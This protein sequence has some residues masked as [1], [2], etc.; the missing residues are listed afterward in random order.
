MSADLVLR[1]ALRAAVAALAEIP[2]P[3]MIIG[4]I[5]VIAAGVPRETV[6]VDATILGKAIDAVSVLDVFARHGIVPRIPNAL[7]FAR[8]RQV[9]LL[10]H[11]RSTVTMEVSFAWLPFEEEALARAVEVDFEGLKLRVAIPEDLIVYKAAAWRDRDVSD[12]E[13]LL[14]LHVKEVDL[15]RVRGLITQIAHALDDPDRVRRFEAIVQRV[16]SGN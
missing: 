13:R 14:V 9:L 11:E 2:A 5:A 1:D 7:E 3:A 15:Q 12:I 16:Q 6:D 4:G 10:R 8:E